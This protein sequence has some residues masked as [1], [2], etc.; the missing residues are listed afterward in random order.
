MKMQ[1]ELEV[2][3]ELTREIASE[4]VS[5]SEEQLSK[6]ESAFLS[7]E[8]GD[9]DKEGLNSAFRAFHTLKGTADYLG[10]RA[11]KDLSHFCE[12]ILD[13][14]RA[15]GRAPEKNVTAWLIKGIDML[16]PAI[17]AGPGN[18]DGCDRD[19]F[20]KVCREILEKMSAGIITGMNTA[21]EQAGVESAVV[22]L[23]DGNPA[24]LRPVI[25]IDAH[26]FNALMNSLNEL[27]VSEAIIMNEFNAPGDAAGR[28]EGIR[29]RINA[30]G[31]ITAR[32][33][34]DSS[35][36]KLLPFQHLFNKMTRLVRDL[37]IKSG[38]KIRL[39]LNGGGTEIDREIIEN[40][41][42][43]LMHIIRNSVDHGIESTEERFKAGKSPSAMVSL[44]A[45]CRDGEIVISVS[46]DGRGL[47]REKII[48]KAAASGLIKA[49][50]EP[51]NEKLC[52]LIM[53]PGFTTADK[54]TELSGRG[55]GMDAVKKA[56]ESL[57]GRMKIKSVSG[58]GTKM[59]MIF[60]VN[61]AMIDGLAVSCCGR[62]YIIPVSNV[63][64][65]GTEGDGIDL[66][67]SY[68][69]GE[70]AWGS[71]SDAAAMPEAGEF[72]AR[73]III[74]MEMKGIR[75]S[76]AVDRIISQQKTAVKNI[77]GLKLEKTMFSG[78]AIMADGKPVLIISPE[79]MILDRA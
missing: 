74:N 30:L 63:E 38:K 20:E 58:Q 48:K 50:D 46:D 54:V 66:I 28:L 22:D 5:E 45:Y 71:C 8:A 52:E 76:M 13:R 27:S 31:R 75:K 41:T 17:K 49:G 2:Q 61:T 25:K 51:D 7:M 70:N 18:F 68:I 79:R 72:R 57:K 23:S 35:A 21:G 56:V 37:S 43:P 47:N 44:S 65:V 33:G 32:L 40:L 73:E 67:N 14:A 34:Y 55:V 59:T 3:L 24:E 69:F 26:K 10:F 60:P 53:T 1:E 39:I 64:S 19:A 11:L 78:A 9:K 36:L 16:K 15:C 6:A 42:E 12:E 4:F 29:S 62:Q 77:P